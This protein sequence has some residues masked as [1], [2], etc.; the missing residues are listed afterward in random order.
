MCSLEE[1][2]AIDKRNQTILNEKIESII[3]SYV[4]KGITKFQINN[5]N[6][7]ELYKKKT[8]VQVADFVV[9]DPPKESYVCVIVYAGT[10]QLEYEHICM[11]YQMTSYEH[12][13]VKMK[14]RE[15][16][17]LDTLGMTVT[18]YDINKAGFV[19]GDKDGDTPKE[20]I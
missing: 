14:G 18:E 2:K 20:T 7:L 10:E 16:V 15:N 1:N 19:E 5:F 17:Y 6:M 8:D 9:V 4:E 11:M 12:N 3:D 13:F